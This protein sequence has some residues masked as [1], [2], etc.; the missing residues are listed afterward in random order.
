VR[1]GLVAGL[2]IVLA[3]QTLTAQP[4]DTTKI[5]RKPLFVKS[6]ALIAAVFVVGTV[7]AAPVDRHVANQL[8]RDS[9]HFNKFVDRSADFFR[10]MGAPGPYFIGPGMYAVGRVIDNKEMADLG[11]HGTE[12]V[13]LGSAIVTVGKGLAGRAR[14]YKDPDNPR[15]FKLNRG[16]RHEEYRSFPSGHSLGGFAAAAAVSAETAR[17]W[18]KTRWIIGPAMY[19]G[20]A[21]VATSR[22]YHNKHWASDVVM[23]AGIGTFAGLKVVRYH[24]SHPGNR[25]DKWLL[26]ANVTPTPAGDVMLSWSV[27]PT[28]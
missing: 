20:A 18:P 6:D 16:W 15:N 19:G 8:R 12:A 26:S 9:A 14:P 25:I 13:L 10:W 17:W 27:M 5:S 21:L 7:A 1:T 2:S 11:L 24:H 3:I 4:A 22:M 23:G 28:K